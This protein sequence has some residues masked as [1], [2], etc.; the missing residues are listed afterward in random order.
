MLHLKGSIMVKQM[1]TERDS[2]MSSANDTVL[3]AGRFLLAGG[4]W[5]SDSGYRDPSTVLVA[6]FV[7]G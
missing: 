4:H 6:P 2:E 3:I 5:L 7:D 1:G